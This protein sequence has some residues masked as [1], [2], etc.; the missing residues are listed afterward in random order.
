MNFTNKTLKY[1]LLA[2]TIVLFSGCSVWEDFTTY[3]NLYFN[4]SLLFE[5]AENDILSQ[6]RDLFSNEP[7]II[8]S[9][10]KAS[11]VKVI[12]K[13]SKLLQFYSNSS[14]V[15]PTLMMLGKSFY[16]QA[17]FQKS[18]RKF[19]E[20]LARNTEDDE[21]ITETNLWIAK[22]SFELNENTEALKILE[23]V[24]IKAVEED[25]E[26]I[27][28][29]SYV[30]EIKYRIKKEEY[31]IAI[32]L[33]T[34]F[35]EVYDDNV[36]RSQVYYELGNLYTLIKDSE[37]AIAAYEKVFDYSP[38]FD[39][40]IIATIKY[41][42]ALRDAG[43]TDKALEVFE[44]IRR[45][46]KFFASFNEIDFE[47]GKTLVQLGE[48][49]EA[50][51]QFV[52][53]DSTYKSTAFA[54]A[55]KFEIAELYRTRFMNYDSAGIYYTKALSSNPPK[56]YVEKTRNYNTLFIKYARLRK[57]INKFDRQLY[58]SQNIDIFKEDSTNYVADSLQ[59]LADYLEKKEMENIWTVVD[60]A[61]QNKMYRDST[62]IKDSIFVKNS[63]NK[64]DSLIRIGE[65]N[66]TDTVGLRKSLQDSVKVRNLARLKDPKNPLNQLSSKQSQIKLDSVKFKRNPPLKLKISIDSAK[67][68]LAKN[69]LELGNLFLAE[70]NIPDSALFHYNNI[71]E[72]YPSKYYYPNTL[73]A[74]GTYYQTIENKPKADSLFKTIYDNYKDRTIVNSAADK[75]GLPLIDLNFDPAKEQYASA[76]DLMLEGKYSQSLS[77]FYN[78]FLEYPKSTVAPQ[79][80]Y[81]SG[82]IL[83]N[84]L[85]LPDSAVVVYD[86]LISKYPRSIYVLQVAKKISTYKQEKARLQKAI[87]DSLSNIAR[88]QKDTT[89]IAKNVEDK[90]S[91]D[92]INQAFGETETV[93]NRI[94]EDTDTVIATDAIIKNKPDVIH[95]KRKL[96]PLWD[97]RKHFN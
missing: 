47:I 70:L 29:E 27:I 85:R 45:K 86:T 97:P 67:T 43:Q 2:A 6:K 56:D 30:Q 41:A 73:Y 20:L 3:F 4:T 49:D 90:D 72:K 79:A 35:A 94:A 9:T 25:Y 33:A 77:R 80:L 5:E 68:I 71:L 78:I 48:Y 36:I 42:N 53:V 10:A 62:M 61:K 11:L 44:D 50:Y 89:F 34:E 37:N 75:L 55:A 22:C 81:T 51:D 31:T 59:I 66:P 87:Q 26:N 74:L 23:S 24:R 28:K 8:S 13:S 32:N 95:Q 12:E 19:E 52:F 15:E 54:G 93:D 40:E 64:V 82:W 96:E 1:Y 16:Y 57:D 7:L 60:T 14:Y 76:E 88:L 18:R 21:I 83:E 58:Y 39:L 63:I 84:D 69:S 38:D 92:V 46:D 91:L 65:M 17:N